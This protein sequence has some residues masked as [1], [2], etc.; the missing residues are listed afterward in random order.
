M[1]LHI[2]ISHICIYTYVY[3]YILANIYIPFQ[4]MRD[5]VTQTCTYKKTICKGG[6]PIW[7][8]TGVNQIGPQRMQ[9]LK[10]KERKKQKL[11]QT[12]QKKE[13]AWDRREERA[14][15]ALQNKGFAIKHEGKK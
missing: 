7:F 14:Y 6:E 15:F 4:E 3:M 2:C 13:D 1:Y 11:P 8:T 5:F 12:C 10:N 9:T